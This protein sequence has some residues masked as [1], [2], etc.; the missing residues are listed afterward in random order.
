MTYID[1]IQIDHIDALRKAGYD[2]TEI[3]EKAAENYC[4]QILE[5]GFFHADPHPGNLWIAGG[6][7]AWLD[8]GMTGHLSEHYKQLL[9]KAITALLMHDIYTLKNVL[10]TLG[11]P[12]DR[13]NHARLYTDVDDIVSRYM[14]LDF[15][16]MRLGDLIEKLLDLVKKHKIA[17]SPDITLLGRSMITMEGTLAACSPEVN[18]LSILSMHM[19]SM[20]YDHFNWKKELIHRGRTAYAS[21]DKSMEIPS[22]LSDLLNI[23]KNGQTKL[24]MELTDA[25]DFMKTFRQSVGYL[26]LGS[27]SSA[28]F[29]GAVLLCMTELRP[30]IF[31][32]PWISFIGFVLSGLIIVYLLYRILFRPKY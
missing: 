3:G 4:K 23:T 17:I 20:I 26:V 29:L 6:K 27:V 31:G 16:E 7:I 8:L 25:N 18:M 2:M 1:G 5:D 14:T 24:N 15:G 13:I 22:Q 19:S 10:L 12:K 11:E 32:I 9:R 28:L 30:L 21:L